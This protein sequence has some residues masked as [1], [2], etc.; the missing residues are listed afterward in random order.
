MVRQCRFRG[1]EAAPIYASAH[2]RVTESTEPG[3]PYT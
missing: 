1:E 3:G 2:M